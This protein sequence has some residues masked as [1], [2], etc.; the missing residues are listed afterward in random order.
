MVYF[1]YRDIV[2]C[3]LDGRDKRSATQ[4]YPLGYRVMRGDVTLLL[5]VHRDLEDIWELN[6]PNVRTSEQSEPRKYDQIMFGRR[7]NC[8]EAAEQQTVTSHTPLFYLCGSDR[9]CPCPCPLVASPSPCVVSPPHLPLPLPALR[10]DDDD[11]DDA[12][13]ASSLWSSLRP[14][15]LALAPPHPRLTLALAL[16][17]TS[18]PRPASP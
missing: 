15:A 10:R 2:D 14:C 18:S 6:F 12:T 16:A 7:L 11:D 9:P 3:P 17:R 5:D 13:I 1:E 4:T 8:A